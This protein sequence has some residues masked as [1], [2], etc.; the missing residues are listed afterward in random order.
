M[1]TAA[2]KYHIQLW[3]IGGCWHRQND[4]H[5]QPIVKSLKLIAMVTAYILNPIL[6]SVKFFQVTQLN[7]RIEVF[8]VMP[9]AIGGFKS[10]LLLRNRASIERLSQLLT[11]LDAQNCGTFQ[12]QMA[13]AKA[14][15]RVRWLTKMLAIGYGCSVLIICVAPLLAQERV[16]MWQMWLPFDYRQTSAA[17]YG[18]VLVYQAIMTVFWFPVMVPADLY[19]STMYLMLTAHLDLLV[20][21]FLTADDDNELRKCIDT[22]K[23]CIE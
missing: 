1:S 20:G 7:E 5:Q 21:R 11:Q 4:D 14:V 12:Q 16:L 2:L 22:H 3:T 19:A 9:S 23:L 13:V 15:R 18:C 8:L 6:M 10:W 17:T